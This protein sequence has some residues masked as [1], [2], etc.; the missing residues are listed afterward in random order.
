MVRGHAWRRTRPAT[1]IFLHMTCGSLSRLFFHFHTNI[2]HPQ[3]TYRS[4][5]SKRITHSSILTVPLSDSPTN[6]S[7][8]HFEACSTTHISQVQL[9][10]VLFYECDHRADELIGLK[11][12]VPGEFITDFEIVFVQE[13]Y[14]KITS[15]L[16]SQSP[17]RRTVG[18]ELKWVLLS[19]AQPKSAH[20]GHHTHRARPPAPRSFP[21]RPPA[22]F[23][24]NGGSTSRLL[25]AKPAAPTQTDEIEH[26]D[27]QTRMFALKV[28]WL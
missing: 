19:A 25:C 13:A 23:F 27:P 20:R 5:F 6:G 12:D 17:A 28:T 18:R 11:A 8:R 9:D 14:K 16:F 4:N 21:R 7:E 15:R 1:S 2:C 10:R 26:E 24:V 22:I 3:K